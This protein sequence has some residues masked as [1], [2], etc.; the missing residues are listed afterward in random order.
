MVA[1]TVV[2]SRERSSIFLC[3]SIRGMVSRGVGAF[4]GPPGS[5]NHLN[6]GLQQYQCICG[7]VLCCTYMCLC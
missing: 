3:P 6:Q 1:L 4:Y 5:R 2:K 7:V